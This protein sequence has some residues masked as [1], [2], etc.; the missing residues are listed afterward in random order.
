M[1]NFIR[2]IFQPKHKAKNIVPFNTSD[3]TAAIRKNRDTL[4]LVD[5]WI[6]EESFRKS[7]FQYGV[8]DFIRDD[9]NKKIDDNQTYTDIM[10]V[11]ARIFFF[12][13][14]LFRNRCFCREKFL[15]INECPEC[16]KNDRI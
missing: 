11:I 4:E 14:K 12:R 16:R 2:E 8:P 3:L 6:D 1:I 5:N 10:L 15:P 9:I 7:W 13:N